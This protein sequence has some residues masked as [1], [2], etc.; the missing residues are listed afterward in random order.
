MSLCELF[1]A[2][3]GA[4]GDRTALRTPGGTVELTWDEYAERVRSIAA[5]LAALGVGRG[6]TVGL[7]LTNRP[8]FHLCDAA[9]RPNFVLS[10]ARW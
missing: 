7:M 6:H 9:E 2:T 8:E 1:Q 3:A 5:G 10:T 4:S